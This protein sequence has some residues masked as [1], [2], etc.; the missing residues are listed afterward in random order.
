MGT[1]GESYDVRC[2]SQ[3]IDPGHI[4][5]VSTPLGLGIGVPNPAT[6]TVF[7]GERCNLP[8]AG[9]M[10]F[11][12]LRSCHGLTTPLFSSMAPRKQCSQRQPGRGEVGV[13]LRTD[14]KRCVLE[15]HEKEES[16]AESGFPLLA[17]GRLKDFLF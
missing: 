9:K 3:V 12:A 1:R 5:S 10:N 4:V 7:L 11:C 13:W 16:R 14:L 6:M 8:K 15:E 17:I 2:E